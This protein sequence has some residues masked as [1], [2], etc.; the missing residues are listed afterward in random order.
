MHEELVGHYQKFREGKQYPQKLWVPP[1]AIIFSGIPDKITQSLIR[2]CTE[3]FRFPMLGQESE[4]HV[5]KDNS[6]NPQILTESINTMS[7]QGLPIHVFKSCQEAI[8]PRGISKPE[9]SIFFEHTLEVNNSL[10]QITRSFFLQISPYI[11]KKG[12]LV[13]RY[14]YFFDLCQKLDIENILVTGACIYYYQGRRQL[15][16]IDT[17]VSNLR[18]L[19]KI[20]SATGKPLESTSSKVGIMKYVNL[21]E[22]DI[23]SDLRLAYKEDDNKSIY[24][25]FNFTE[26]KSDAQRVNLFGL[27]ALITSPE[28]TVL[29]KMYLGRYGV[30][31]WGLPK[32]DYE[33]TR[34]V[35][36]SQNVDLASLEK[37]AKKLGALDR[38][39]LG[40]KILGLDQKRKE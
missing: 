30:D 8:Q 29:M 35:I 13:D 33:D 4:K 38:V 34:G 31:E 10:D 27:P 36:I 21:G 3:T 19:E 25:D 26:L 11:F 39:I 6:G 12:K 14:Y 18:D 9:E 23:L 17:V 37:R 15:E 2:N 5:I 24:A 32:D 7:R 20:S 40:E 28:M 16:D 1:L 22:V